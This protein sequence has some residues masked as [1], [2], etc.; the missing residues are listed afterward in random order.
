MSESSDS[1][2]ELA[3]RVT[4]AV[5]K[6][7]KRVA[8]PFPACAF[9]EAIEFSKQILSFGSGQ[10]VRRLSLFDHL[11][12]SPESGPSRQ[13][14]TNAGKYGLI[15]GSYSAEQIRLTK[16]GIKAVDDEAPKRE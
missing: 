11:G 4:Q 7:R 2:K 13:L 15:E 12:K 3:E 16:D 9:E 8:R 1:E 5:I 14:I 6:K 10:P